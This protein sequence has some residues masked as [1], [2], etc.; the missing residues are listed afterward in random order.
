MLKHKLIISAP[1]DTGQRWAFSYIELRLFGH[2]FFLSEKLAEIK[3]PEEG[4][5]Y[6]FT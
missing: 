4:G 1:T 6:R 3:A 2:R 5:F